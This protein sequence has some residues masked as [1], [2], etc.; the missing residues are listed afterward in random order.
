MVEIIPVLDIRGGVAVAG[1]S[2]NREEYRPL[3]T[4]FAG[5]SDPA[6]IASA[7]PYPR[8]YVADLDGIVTGRPDIGT[9]KSLS[10]LKDLMVDLGVRDAYDLQLFSDLSCDIVLGTETVSEMRVITEAIRRFGVGRIIVSLDIKMGA[11]LS[12][13]LQH[14]PQNAYDMLSAVGV[15][16]VIFLD[17]SMVGTGKSDYRFIKNLNKAGEIIL[18]GGITAEDFGWLKR[19]PVD[20]VLVGTALHR[21]ELEVRQNGS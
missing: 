8:L 4:V 10:Q 13:F 19:A 11:V 15:R 16:R 9:L 17:I 18:G 14:H 3:E 7:L 5:G 1:K 6:A 20:G 2:G 21:G 12:D